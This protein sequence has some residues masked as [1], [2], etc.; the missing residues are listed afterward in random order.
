MPTA[1]Q[2][3]Q[4]GAYEGEIEEVMGKHDYIKL[5]IVTIQLKK[6]E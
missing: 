6:E 1:N 3:G 2:E 4:S 5:G